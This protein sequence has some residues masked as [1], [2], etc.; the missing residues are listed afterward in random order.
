MFAPLI[1]SETHGFL[2]QGTSLT[3]RNLYLGAL[4]ASY[5]LTQL[6]GAPVLGEYS[7]LAGRKKA[8]Y[9]SINGVAVGF[10]L[11]GVACLT[12]NL[13]LLFFSRLFTGFF[14]ANL[15]IC[16]SAVADISPDEK[17][18]SKNFTT[19]TVVGGIAWS[20]AMLI[21]GLF[22]NPSD[23]SFFHPSIP[24]W[25]AAF[26]SFQS[27]VAVALFYTETHEPKKKTSIN[28]AKGFHDLQHAFTAK[29]IRPYLIIVLFWALG[30]G[31][32]TQ[33]FS[34]YSILEYAVDQDTIAWTLLAQTIFWMIG[35]LICNPLLL[36]KFN[37]MTITTIGALL[38]GVTLLA[39]PLFS[40]FYFF[41]GVYWLSIL[42]AAFTFS[43]TMNLV[44]IHASDEDQGKIMG[45]SQS[46]FSLAWFIVP[47]I[48][49]VIGG[50]NQDLFYPVAALFILVVFVLLLIQRRREKRKKRHA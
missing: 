42:F 19:L 26:L 14:A 15:G 20:I 1:L 23:S 50:Q 35:G 22:S 44:S 17:E 39:V 16:L 25:L 34:T 13:Y 12:V 47:V 29:S 7:D 6:I 33:W 37:S 27:L 8:L 18:R 10:I 49:G 2:P 45:L 24:F 31:L 41:V 9:V 28:F 21:G 32:A 43:N 36:K 5:P 3:V 38:G 4:F 46:M 30:R 48:G 11:S 40:H